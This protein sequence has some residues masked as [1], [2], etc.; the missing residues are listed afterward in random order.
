MPDPSP[1]RVQLSVVVTTDRRPFEL[2]QCLATLE[3]V[4]DD[5]EADELI[6]VEAAPADDDVPRLLATTPLRATHAHA[7]GPRPGALLDAGWRAASGDVAV[8]L[9]DACRVE[10][11]AL[12]AY[13]RA[14]RTD[15][16]LAAAGGPVSLSWPGA[17]PPHWFS[18]P[19]ASY[20]SALDARRSASP[21]ALPVAANMAL[22]R[23]DL[24]RLGGFDQRGSGVSVQAAADDVLRALD[25]AGRHIA[26]VPDA[27][28]T[29]RVAPDQARVAWVLGRA[30]QVGRAD[31]T[32]GPAAADP[33]G[34]SP[35]GRVIAAALAGATVRGW[36]AVAARRRTEAF[37]TVLAADATR[38][39]RRLGRAVGAAGI[40]RG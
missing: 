21:G 19:L 18:S 20:Y 12:A 32:S 23:A 13:R 27:A 38:R 26:M 9:E 15:P 4:W 39:A 10:P 11:G 5:V 7:A 25:A 1:A 8:F 33:T 28:V 14:F 2:A 30:L 3:A 34:A 17:A 16:D 36:G 29:L 37:G 6:V 35:P 22:R 24:D 31:V 40:A